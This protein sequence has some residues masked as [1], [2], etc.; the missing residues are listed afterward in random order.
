MQ[1]LSRSEDSRS[2]KV[3]FD[4][5]L[6][7]PVGKG[8]EVI[9]GDVRHYF[10]PLAASEFPKLATFPPR[11]CRQVTLSLKPILQSDKQR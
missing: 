3:T 5:V 4:T 11:S 2:Y 6:K 1:M 9:C 10:L 8:S 7:Y